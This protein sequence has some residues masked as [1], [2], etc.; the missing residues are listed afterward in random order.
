MKT[1]FYTCCLLFI[2][3]QINAQDFKFGHVSKQEVLQQAHP[4]D[5]DANA[6]VL[7]REHKVSYQVIENS[8]FALTTDIHERIKIYNK[9][10]FERATKEIPIYRDGTTKEKITSLKGYTYNLVDGKLVKEKL[11][12][13]GIFE[14]EVNDHQELTKFTMPAVKEGSVIEIRYRIESPFL[15][16]IDMLPLQYAIPINHLEASVR[17]PE[18]LVF[19]KHI[20]LRSPVLL[21]VEEKQVNVSKAFGGSRLS[22]L[23]NIYSINADNIPGLKNE[24]YVDYLHNYLAYLKW[25]LQY[26]NLPNS[27]V[28]NYTATWENVVK[29]I[30]N[31]DGYSKELGR[32]FFE[33]DLRKVLVG[34]TTPEEK[35]KVVY[36]L[37]KQKVKW[38]EVR[39]L[40]AQKG[41]KTAWKEGAGNVA[42]INLLLTAMLKTA[43]L[44]A[45][46]V[47]LSTRDNGIPTFPTR[48][49]FNY[50]ISA[51][52]L[53]NNNFVL[54]DATE[55]NSGP[56]ELPARARNWQGR[57]IQEDGNSTWLSLMPTYVS[58]D[59]KTINYK[60]DN[61][62]VLK[63]KSIRSLNGLYAKS[64]RDDY[65]KMAAEDF[66]RKLE[67]DKGNI[68]ISNVAKENEEQLGNE[69]T[70][71]FEFE[72]KN[73]V[74]KINDKIYLKPMLFLARGENPFKADHRTIPV[75]FDYPS[76]NKKT[77][78]LMLPQ[79][80]K[81]ESLPESVVY[82]FKNGSGTYKF[83]VTQNG[84]FLRLESEFSL[85]KTVYTST[86]YP[87]LKN[88]FGR[89][90]EKQTE[91]I[92]LSKI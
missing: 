68:I 85:S 24:P 82:D 50:V 21:D 53:P 16:N 28:E 40:T 25:E 15:L 52:K 33:E 58:E 27:A 32:D 80:Y 41:V 26:T 36:D 4:L 91:A 70:E 62:L 23:E 37:V 65:S 90:V 2:N 45:Y 77:V 74:E 79:G 64:F 84:N 10:G 9:E 5:D 20:N 89:M 1:L 57:I 60:F 47:L 31:N 75:F 42:D 46:P 34:T 12:K 88:F 83:V 35:L 48:E 6:A 14:E 44:R 29:N 87:S 76:L 73:G 51:V 71:T 69:I 61:N 78:N 63:G 38:N 7:F 11:S 81:V 30:Y 8:G 72:L 92:V 67:E 54:L 39:G 17:I 19:K 59:H 49:G 43:G 56:G 55:K 86:D 13:G 22:Y 18:F 66:L 3:L